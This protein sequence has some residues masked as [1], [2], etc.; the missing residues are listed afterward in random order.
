VDAF[1]HPIDSIKA[2]WNDFI[3]N[4]TN[5]FK[6]VRVIFS[7]FENGFNPKKLTDGLIQLTTGVSNAT[8]KINNAIKNTKKFVNDSTMAIRKAWESGKIASKEEIE[9]IG[10]NHQK[11]KVYHQESIKQ[12]NETKQATKQAQEERTA[13]AAKMAKDAMD[14][15]SQE[16]AETDEHYRQL[17]TKYSDY[18]AKYNAMSDAQQQKHK[19][20]HDAV[21][22]AQG[23]LRRY[24]LL[25]LVL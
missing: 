7:A 21:K 3:E 5:R 25:V 8:N 6:A 18:L 23:Q 10:K 1:L 17:E 11:K 15:Y 12:I 2:I 20:E 16:L 22:A 24:V 14:P 13:S 4:I 19:Q 9:E